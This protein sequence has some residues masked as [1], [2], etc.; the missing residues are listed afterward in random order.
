MSAAVRQPRRGLVEALVLAALAATTCLFASA[1]DRGAH[2]APRPRVAAL[3]AL[4]FLELMSLGYRQVAADLSWL[5]AVQYYGEY[6]QGGNDLSQ[7]EHFVQ[8]VNTLDPRFT[9][10]YVFGAT[11]LATDGRDLEAGLAVLRRGA[12]ANPGSLVYPFEMGFLSYVAGGDPEAALRWFAFAARH[13]ETPEGGRALRFQAYLN[14]RLGRLETAW[15]LWKDLERT[16]TDHGMRLV[17]ADNLRR[18][19][20]ELRQRGKR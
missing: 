1:G 6:R 17:A 14:R 8:A 10:A 11:V 9:H 15:M 19:E 5:Q 7:F 4:P 13:P 20:A 12:T 18:L 2:G 16:A 3:P